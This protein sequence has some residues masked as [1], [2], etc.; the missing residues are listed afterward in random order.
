MLDSCQHVVDKR[1]RRRHSHACTHADTRP[2]TCMHTDTWHLCTHTHIRRRTSARTDTHT[3]THTHADT[4]KYT[5]THTHPNKRARTRTHACRHAHGMHTHSHM[6]ADTHMTRAEERAPP[7]V[8]QPGK[9]ADSGGWAG[10]RERRGM[11]YSESIS[12]HT[13]ITTTENSGHD[14]HSKCMRQWGKQPYYRPAKG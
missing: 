9:G 7:H 5:R 13:V 2:H 4:Y 11:G 1:E 10:G 6:H 14:V 8:C 3:H 12:V